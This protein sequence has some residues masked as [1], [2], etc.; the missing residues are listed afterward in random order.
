M[1]LI[2]VALLNR[3]LPPNVNLLTLEPWDDQGRILVRFEHFFGVGEDETFSQPASISLK[4]ISY[5]RPKNTGIFTQVFFLFFFI[6]FKQGLFATLNIR[7]V[8]EVNLS[9]N[10]P[11]KILDTDELVLKPMEIRTLILST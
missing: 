6:F 9:S 5:N 8:E 1:L 4:V 7:T 10:R 11:I 2:K 3:D